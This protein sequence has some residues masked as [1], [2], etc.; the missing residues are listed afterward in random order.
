[1]Q[2]L[3][4]LV[5]AYALNALSDAERW[6]FEEHLAECETCALDIR[7]LREATSRLGT[8]V[9]EQ[10]PAALRGRVFAEIAG[11]RQLPPAPAGEPVRRPAEQRPPERRDD[12]REESWNGPWDEA[13]EDRRDDR[14]AEPADTSAG[15]SPGRRSRRRPGGARD[16]RRRPGGRPRASTWLLSAAA[17]VLMAVSV[18]LGVLTVQTRDRAD[19]VEA[20]GRD[21]V[22]VL[23]A[24]DARTVRRAVSGGGAGTVVVS[25][26]KGR[27]VVM[28]AGLTSLPSSQTYELWLLGA[29]APKPAGLLKST[30]GRTGAPMLVRDLGSSTQ[31]GLTVEPAGGSNSP[32][33]DPVF[34]APLP[35]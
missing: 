13:W 16:R 27:A 34:V 8:A 6:R 19:R 35:G 3:H 9:A 31:V 2:E 7:G 10:P 20:A 23:S 5:G 21:L 26:G 30:A 28:L 24:P 17:A 4:S 14:W 12:R 25:K 33:S 15:R 22:E 32:T 11:V 18:T 29:G 1:M